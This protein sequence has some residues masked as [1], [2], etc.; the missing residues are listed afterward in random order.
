M[1]WYSGNSQIRWVCLQLIKGREIS[2]T[3]EIAEAKGWRLAAIIHN[4]KHKYK[5]GIETRYGESRVAYYRLGRGVDTEA[6]KK[7]PSFKRKREDSASTLPPEDN[8]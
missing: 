6:L 3:H 1:R 8:S 7:P 5:W 4:L 2:H